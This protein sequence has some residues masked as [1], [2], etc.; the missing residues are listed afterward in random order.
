MAHRKYYLYFSNLIGLSH[1][2]GAKQLDLPILMAHE[3]KDWS[4]SKHRYIYTHHL[5]HKMAKDV[6]S[7]CIEGMRSSSGTDSWHHRNGYQ[8]APKA[9]EGFLHHKEQG[10]VCRLMHLF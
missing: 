5:H 1:G 2:D 10:Q 4:N 3:S 7:V 6:M 9:I 8:H